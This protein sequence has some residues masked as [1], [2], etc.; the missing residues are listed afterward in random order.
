M[1]LL[2]NKQK[3]NLH[4]GKFGQI[5]FKPGVYAYIGSA[6]GPGGIKARVDRHLRQTDKKHWHIDYIK[7]AMTIEEVWLIYTHQRLEHR[8]AKICADLEQ[9]QN[10]RPGFGS[11][12]CDCKTHLYYYPKMPKFLDFKKQLSMKSDKVAVVR[13]NG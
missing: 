9:A 3:Q 8:C 1:L 6:F 4:V 7:S 2:R 10:A 11:S 5:L 12:D 13:L